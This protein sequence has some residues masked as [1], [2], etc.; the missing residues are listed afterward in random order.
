[1]CI[2][3]TPT[4]TPPVVQTG[5][6]R[7]PRIDD[8]VLAA[9]RALLLDV[10]YAGMS[11]DLV[12]QR[13]GVNRPAIYRR[14]P[15]LAHLVHQAVFGAHRTIAVVETGDFAADLRALARSIYLAYTRPE[16]RAA[17]AGML[18]D[19]HDHPDLRASVIDGLEGQVREQFAGLLE[20]ARARGDVRGVN[21]DVV[22]DTIIGA[23][24]HSAIAAGAPDRD[25]PPEFLDQLLDLLLEGLLH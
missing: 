6:P 24:F 17:M 12:A 3:T 25:P 9:A 16:V 19:L 20:R 5:R 1:V 23:L 15:T 8:A 4:L 2:I 10:G 14:W 11:I 7:D 21:A 22:L 13:A 18:S